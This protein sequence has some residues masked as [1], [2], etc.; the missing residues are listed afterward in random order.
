MIA[1]PAVGVHGP[2]RRKGKRQKSA[3]RLCWWSWGYMMQAW[4][5]VS[6]AEVVRKDRLGSVGKAEL[7]ELGDMFLQALC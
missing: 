4:P 2:E 6:T 5:R 3:Q 7:E 1:V